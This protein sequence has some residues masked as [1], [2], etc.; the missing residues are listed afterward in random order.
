MGWSFGRKRVALTVSFLLLFAAAAE[1][2][3]DEVPVPR[4]PTLAGAV[5]AAA[6]GTLSVYSGGA[7][8]RTAAG[9][10]ALLVVLAVA[11]WAKVHVLSLQRPRS[12]NGHSVRCGSHDAPPARRGS[13]GEG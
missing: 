4:S 2:A 12:S 3:A 9:E 10:G 5:A 7:S 11:R 6:S 8:C 1:E 13:A